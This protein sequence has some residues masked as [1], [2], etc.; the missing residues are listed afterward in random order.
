MANFD[1]R[2]SVSRKLSPRAIALS[3]ASGRA[4]L[5]ALLWL[6]ALVAFG[7]VCSLLIPVYFDNYQL[8]DAMKDEARYAIVE[9][10]DQDQIQVDVYRAAK[11]LGIPARMEGIDVEP[12]EGGYRITVDYTVPLQ[13]FYH[14]TTADNSSV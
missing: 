10:K 13:I 1:R 14:H 5:R 7:Y 3:R 2:A 11:N 12:I 8:Q 4:M 9:H 6:A